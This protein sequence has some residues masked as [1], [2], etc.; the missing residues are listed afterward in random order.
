MQVIMQS[1]CNLLALKLFMLPYKMRADLQWPKRI[2]LL[3]IRL[4][5]LLS[6]TNRDLPKAKHCLKFTDK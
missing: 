5:R 1:K 6:L 4:C 2:I 3:A